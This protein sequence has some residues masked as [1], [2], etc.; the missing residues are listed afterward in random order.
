M[1]HR[2]GGRSVSSTD[3]S[4]QSFLVVGF[5]GDPCANEPSA[6]SKI[7]LES[8]GAQQGLHSLITRFLKMWDEWH[9]VLQKGRS[10]FCWNFL[11]YLK[12]L[13]CN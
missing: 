2:A 10:S 5:L 8:R 11:L 12:L 4:L 7:T 9:L 3:T 6:E 1:F 13:W